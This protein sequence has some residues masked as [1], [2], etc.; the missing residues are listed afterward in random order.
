MRSLGEFIQLLRSLNTLGKTLRPGLN[1]SAKPGE[2]KETKICG[3]QG[4]KLKATSEP[5]FSYNP[6]PK[7]TRE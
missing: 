6:R 5:P 7:H 2:I 1:S 3:T 4:R